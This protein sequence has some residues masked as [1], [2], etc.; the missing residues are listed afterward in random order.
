ML[1]MLMFVIDILLFLRFM[2]KYVIR[3]FAW[4]MNLVRKQVAAMLMAVFVTANIMWFAGHASLQ[5]LHSEDQ[6]REVPHPERYYLR[7]PW[8]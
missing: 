8:F 7:T 1:L 5:V 2:M 3:L 4:Q 6:G